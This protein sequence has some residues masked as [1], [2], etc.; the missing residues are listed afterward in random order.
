MKFLVFRN[1]FAAIALCVLT[2]CTSASIDQTLTPTPVASNQQNL[3]QNTSTDA[4]QSSLGYA[5]EDP[6]ATN[7]ATANQVAAL[8]LSNSVTFLPVEGAPQSAST[9]LSNS[10]KARAQVH[11]LSIVPTANSGAKYRIKGYFSALNDGTGT[12][13]VYIWDVIDASGKRVHR[14][15]GRERSGETSINPW[16]SITDKEINA[17]ADITAAKLKSWVDAR[18]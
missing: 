13:L 10:L 16:Q 4:T 1:V 15:N 7:S 17:M 5:T 18:A 9:T 14:I 3:P 12:L 11:G 6:S 8:N 2:A